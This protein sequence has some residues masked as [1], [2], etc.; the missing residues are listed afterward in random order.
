MTRFALVRRGRFAAREPDEHR[1][2]E[3]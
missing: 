2:P 3:R 1:E